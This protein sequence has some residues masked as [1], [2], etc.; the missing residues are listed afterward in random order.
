M[1]VLENDEQLLDQGF[2]VLFIEF[3]F[4]FDLIKKL[5]SFAYFSHQTVMLLV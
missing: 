5:T 3:A 2:T 4:S 1:T